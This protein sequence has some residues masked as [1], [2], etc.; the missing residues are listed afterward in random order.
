MVEYRMVW[1]WGARP[2]QHV[3]EQVHTLP[4]DE[5][6]EMQ[7]WVEGVRGGSSV[8]GGNSEG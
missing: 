2:A 4:R 3:G 1:G 6:G 5:H 7:D 8:R